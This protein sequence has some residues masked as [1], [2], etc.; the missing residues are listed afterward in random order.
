MDKE[1]QCF[2]NKHGTEFDKSVK[3][4]Y[5]QLPCW[6][7]VVERLGLI[8]GE[9][10]TRIALDPKNLRLDTT[11]FKQEENVNLFNKRG[12]LK[13]NS[14]KAKELFKSYQQIIEEEGLRD[15]ADMTLIRFIYGV[16]KY[17][18]RTL[19][20]YTTSENDIY[21]KADFDLEEKTKGLV[22][23]ISEIE[24]EEKYLEELKKK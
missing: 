20:S 2:K 18:G 4:H 21:Y 8:M 7:K 24:Y 12:E 15:F 1:I 11:E 17:P 3:K 9:D 6:K 19:E 16:M 22:V 13:K 5:T 23:P 14:K 10:I